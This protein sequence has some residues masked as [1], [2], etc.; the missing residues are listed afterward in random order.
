MELYSKHK[1][2]QQTGS[3]QLAGARSWRILFPGDLAIVH[4][5]CSS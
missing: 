2:I 1:E 5:P 3:L 4:P